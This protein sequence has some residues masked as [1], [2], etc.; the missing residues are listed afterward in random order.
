MRLIKTLVVVVAALACAQPAMASDTDTFRKPSPLSDQL[1]AEIHAAGAKGVQ[2]AEEELNLWCPGVQAPGVSANGCIVAPYGCTANFIFSNGTG[3][4]TNP[5]IGTA[6]HC[7]DKNGEP[8][9][10]QVD[11]TT[12]AEVGTVY[13]QTAGEEPGN[14]FALI[15]IYP[16]VAAKWGVNPAIPTG[17]PQGI[18]TGCDPQVVKNYGHGYGVAVGQGKP[19]AGVAVDWYSDGYGWFGAGIMGDSG[20]GITIQD[21]RSAGNFTHIIL[22]DLRGIYTPGE[23]TGMRT[24]K[25]LEFL[26]T[27]WSQVNAD[28]SLSRATGAPCPASNY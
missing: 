7:S 3:W 16:E 14:D 2:V 1:K 22:V 28:G 17:G 4:R 26:G 10:M 11:T 24:T 6:S 25:I 15:Q 20:S 12:L 19:E 8:V 13:R 23:L 9:I 18:Y 27:G 21:N 5:Y